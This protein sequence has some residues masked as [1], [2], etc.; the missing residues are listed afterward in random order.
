MVVYGDRLKAA[1]EACGMKIPELASVMGLSYQAVKKVLD[2]NTTAFTAS[3]NAEVSRILGINSDW[4]ATG[5]GAMRPHTDAN[6]APAEIGS[7]RIPLVSYVQAGDWSEPH[8]P[9]A[10]E[11]PAEYLLTDMKL[12]ENAFALEIKG[13]SM[14]PEFNPGDRVIIDPAVAPSPGDYVAA[15]NGGHEAVFKKYRPRST[16][17][18]GNVV[19][20]LTPLNPDYPVMRSDEC[21]IRIVGTMVEHRRYRKPR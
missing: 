9:I 12:S 16:D 20:E 14:T 19:F 4:L 3:N 6:S 2:G 17:G 10:A 1:M 18:M 8:S 21:V 5:K 11:E 15:M 13:R 7:R